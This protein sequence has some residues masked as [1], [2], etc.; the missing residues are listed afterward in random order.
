LSALLPAASDKEW[1]DRERF[2]VAF[3]QLTAGKRT[4]A[5]RFLAEVD[6]AFEEF[7]P[8]LR[9]ATPAKTLAQYIVDAPAVV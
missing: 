6:K 4:T 9:L 3:N 1:N 5:P 8:V 7:A 2:L